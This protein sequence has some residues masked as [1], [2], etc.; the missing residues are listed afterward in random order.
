MLSMDE[1]VEVEHTEEC[2]WA[3]RKVKKTK[4][5]WQNLGL[6]NC[7]TCNGKVLL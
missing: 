6:K 3:R 4:K 5:W 7:P 1:F 2:D